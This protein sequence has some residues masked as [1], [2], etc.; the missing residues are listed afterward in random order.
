MCTWRPWV[1]AAARL[2]RDKR[3]RRGGRAH[4][5]RARGGGATQDACASHGLRRG[6]GGVARAQDAVQHTR[7]RGYA[8]ALEARETT[9][10]SSA[11]LRL[12]RLVDARR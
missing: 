2:R 9:S 6:T 12:A 5:A 3:V 10:T 1:A 7:P 4:G 11:P 8:R